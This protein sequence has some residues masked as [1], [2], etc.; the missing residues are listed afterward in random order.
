MIE[1]TTRVGERY[2][3]AT[4]EGDNKCLEEDNKGRA[5]KS[6]RE[7]LREGENERVGSEGERDNE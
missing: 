5:R 3:L 1:T 4:S 6:L 7:S 2:N